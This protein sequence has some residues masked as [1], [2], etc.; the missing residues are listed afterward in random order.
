MATRFGFAFGLI[1]AIAMSAPLAW[2]QPADP[3]PDPPP[4]GSPPVDPLFDDPAPEPDPAPTPA[5]PDQIGADD[6]PESDVTGAA[7]SVSD[8]PFTRGEPQY[9]AFFER[10]MQEAHEPFEFHGYFRSGFGI[11]GNGASQEQFA[12]PGAG[13]PGRGSK[14]RLGNEIESYID[15]AFAYTQDFDTGSYARGQVTVG[16][17]GF[18]GF[19]FGNAT[20]S[21]REAFAQVG[22]VVGGKPD[23]KFWAGQR[24]YRRHDI[25]V[26]DFFYNDNSGFGGGFEDIDIGFGKLAGALLGASDATAITDNGVLAEA[27]LDFRISDIAAGSGVLTLGVNLAIQP[28]GDVAGV[29]VGGFGAAFTG[30]FVTPLPSAS[31][32]GFLGGF[33]KASV[34]FGFG[35]GADFG[36]FTAA[37]LDETSSVFRLQVADQIVV[38][39]TPTV[40]LAGVVVFQLSDVDDAALVGSP[41][42]AFDGIWVSA[43]A[44]PV[45]YLSDHFSIAA[46]AGV[47]IV[48][49]G[50]DADGGYVGKLTVAPQIH[51]GKSFWSR[52]SVR[53]FA[54]LAFWNEELQGQVGGAGYADDQV[55][56]SFGVQ[57]ESWW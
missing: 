28:G 33:N 29:D 37:T 40:D 41:D 57:A 5:P 42:A 36:G 1:S 7:D 3:S 27:N 2:A 26:T 55:G 14:Y 23:L 16:L 46:E 38:R 54:T 10:L 52:P 8:T 53:A 39:L 51:P 30:F 48:D 11:S 4:D 13:T 50:E 24:Y 44:R 18:N 19:D 49:L 22:G 32:G 6:A 20:P 45:F 35:P 43:G 56:L 17:D 21:V 47:D 9:S 34:Q 31:G 15:A 25:H 12:A